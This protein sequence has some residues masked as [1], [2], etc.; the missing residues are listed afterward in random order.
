MKLVTFTAGPANHLRFGALVGDDVI[1]FAAADAARRAG[2]EP[3]PSSLKGYIARHGRD[4]APLLALVDWVGRQGDAGAAAPLRYRRA[5]VR[6]APPIPNPGKF[7]CVGKNNREHL[8]EL[9][10]NQLL[11]ETPTEPTGFLKLNQVLV[12]DGA[13]V[14]RP[15]GI[16][17]FDYEPEMAFVIARAGY[18]ISKA[19][20]M[21]Y[22]FGVTMLN[23]L[24]AREVQ[25]REVAMNTRFLT[26][27]NMP[28]FGPV[29]PC[30]VTLDE[31]DPHD[32]RLTCTVNGQMRMRADTSGL[33]FRIPDIIE[34]YSRYM[35]VEPGDVFSTGSAGGVAVGKPNASELYLK[36]GD[37]VE[38]TC[39]RIGTL[40]TYIVAP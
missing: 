32:L 15:D 9:R 18:R 30:V 26:A 38:V 17:E 39:E 4:V 28:G 3:L 40:R 22:V 19:E 36:P 10:R 11:H 24:S 27:K 6:L 1:D 2:G 25:K 20:A 8:E 13:S 21:D 35:P 7:F 5:D 37:I 12:G 23:D 33:I 31:L 34:H 29:G 14:A 16:V